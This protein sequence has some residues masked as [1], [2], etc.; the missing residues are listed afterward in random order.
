MVD[1]KK[2]DRRT[3]YTQSVIR[4]AFIKLYSKFPIGRITVTDICKMAEINRGTFYLHYHDPYDLLEQMTRECSAKIIGHIS[5]KLETDADPL[6]GMGIARFTHGLIDSDAILGV[7][8]RKQ[9]SAS[10]MTQQI[11]EGMA[12]LFY[13]IL[14]DKYG[15]T[16]TEAQSVFTFL[17]SGY[18][19]VYTFTVNQK[20]SPEETER[21][22]G[23]L[24]GMVT[25]GAKSFTVKG[26]KNTGA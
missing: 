18:S 3:R 4:E 12:A 6:H 26:D 21:I 13:P 15:F 22:N 9:P 11:Y 10:D 19:A 24:V 7:L 23:V 17:F 16:K 2:T 5:E 14:M 1:N 25:N 20:M 8:I